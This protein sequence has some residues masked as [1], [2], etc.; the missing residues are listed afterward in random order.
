MFGFD[1]AV[2]SVARLTPANQRAALMQITMRSPFQLPHVV[3]GVCH[4]G[5][6]RLPSGKTSHIDHAEHCPVETGEVEP[7]YRAARVLVG[8]LMDWLDDNVP[9]V[10]LASALHRLMEQ[11]HNRIWLLPTKRIRLFYKRL[12]EAA[13]AELAMDKDQLSEHSIESFWLESNI[14]PNILIGASAGTQR[15]LDEQLRELNCITNC[16]RFLC[17]TPL[18]ERVDFDP[19]GL[20]W[21]VVGGEFGAWKPR[22]GD[23]RVFRPCHESDIVHVVNLCDQAKVPV[24]VAGDAHPWPN[25]QGRLPDNIWS[26]KDNPAI[27]DGVIAPITPPEPPQRP[28]PPNK[29]KQL[30]ETR[31]K[32]LART[33]LGEAQPE[34]E[35]ASTD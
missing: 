35:T 28:P 10:Y 14:P 17:L 27:P 32:L 30:A 19:T 7:Y 29:Y 33:M 24:F 2:D 31:D 26:R 20:A 18:L 12:R 5:S 3:C 21:V 9:S 23:M 13:V 25:R 34:E 22:G 16:A 6:V 11:H 4:L 8:S 1:Y 15:E